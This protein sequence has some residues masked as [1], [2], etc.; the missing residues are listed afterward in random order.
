MSLYDVGTKQPGD[1]TC[2]T[3]VEMR[4][5]ELLGDMVKEG[6]ADTVLNTMPNCL[7]SLLRAIEK[8]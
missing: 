7:H 8:H 3:W 1:H 6:C 4:W 2:K 5:G